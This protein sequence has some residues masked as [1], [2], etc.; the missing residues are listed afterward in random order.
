MAKKL[1]LSFLLYIPLIIYLPKYLPGFIINSDIQYVLLLSLLFGLCLFFIS[2]LGDFLTIK[3]VGFLK[4]VLSLIIIYILFWGLERYTPYM[5]MHAAV[6]S[7]I[8][9]IGTVHLNAVAVR[10]IASLMTG[11][12]GI[13]IQILIHA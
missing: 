9:R 8:P 1:A 7:S 6:I 10:A 2:M 13:I 11:F 12:W 5:D 3:K 4:L